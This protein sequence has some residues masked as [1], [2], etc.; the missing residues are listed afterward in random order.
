MTQVHVRDLRGLARLAADATVELTDLV[1]EVHS[2]IVYPPWVPS[3]AARGRTHGIAGLV[4]A[5]IRSTARFAN[6]AI[7]VALAQLAA[8]VGPPASSPRREALLAA[9]NGVLGDH[10]AATGNELAIPMELRRDGRP[11]R[12]EPDA[13]RATIPRAAGKVVV[14]VH[15]LCMSDIGWRRVGHDHGAALARDLGYTALYLRYNSGLH[16]STNGRAFAALLDALLG[17]WPRAV[18]ELAIV[19]HSM[20]G[21]VARSAFHYGLLAGHR[22]PRRLRKLVFLGTPH[23]GVPLERGGNWL[24][25]I[26]GFAPY[27]A[28]FARLGRI[29]SAGITDLRYGNLLDEAWEGCDRFAPTRDRRRPVPLPQGPR[30]YAIAATKGKRAGDL[31]D[32]L[33]GDGLVPVAS[34]LGYHPDPRR[35]LSFGESQQWVAY[36]TGHLEL[37]S[38]ERVYERIRQWLAS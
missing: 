33:L 9:L 23:H 12:L 18:E 10:L 11:L 4:Y 22:W 32:L 5:S 26:V 14:L 20:G 16:I 27:A 38:S 13:L 17:G 34:A 3:L 29:R 24:N 1:E 36:G 6:G 37:L 21:L 31:G 19:G 28:P 2:T 8:R 7:D 30:S 15:G 35:S 25:V